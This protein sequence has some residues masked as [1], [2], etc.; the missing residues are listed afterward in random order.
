[1]LRLYKL[2]IIL[3]VNNH[4]AICLYSV[5]GCEEILTKPGIT[6]NYEYQNL[7][8][9]V[10]VAIKANLMCQ[11]YHPRKYS[12]ISGMTCD[13]KLGEWRGQLP[14]CTGISFYPSTF[15]YRY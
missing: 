7:T 14:S 12:P 15:K 11:E 13:T 9:Y 4:Q 2:L 8:K 1:M 5:I 6:V 10:R 3:T